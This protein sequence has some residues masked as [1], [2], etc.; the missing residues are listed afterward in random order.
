MTVKLDPRRIAIILG[1]AVVFLALADLAG[2]ISTYVF[3]HEN[4]FGIVPLFNLGR[5]MLKLDKEANVGTWYTGVLLLLCSL[6]LFILADHTKRERRGYYWFHWVFLSLIFACLSLDEVAA[7]HER[8]SWTLTKMF[9]TTHYFHYAWLVPG[10]IFSFLMFII[11]IKFLLHL[12][13]KTM[14]QFLLAGLLYVCGAVG[15][16]SLESNHYFL[17]G[18][19]NLTYALYTNVE[20]VLE[21]SGLVVFIHGLLS[22]WNRATGGR[23]TTISF[24]FKQNP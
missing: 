13:R 6:L 20:E 24:S 15:F 14:Y 3:G 12:P 5:E 7:A 21:M 2:I 9:E 18:S 17:H 23:P 11:Y 19:E 16:E 4:L 8:I 10:I 1:A 22:Y